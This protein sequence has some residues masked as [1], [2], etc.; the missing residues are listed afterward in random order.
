MYS[1]LLAA[2]LVALSSFLQGSSAFT[3][4]PS[5]VSHRGSVRLEMGKSINKQAELRRKM[6]QAKRQNLEESMDDTE[7]KSLLTDK[8]IKERNDR[9][10][11]AELLKKES[12]NVLNDYSADGYL[13]RQQEEE[14]ITASRT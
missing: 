5:F 6:E 8:E 13:N 10:R 1:A 9:L 3:L 4:R 14:E 2:G 7:E 11:F 12:A